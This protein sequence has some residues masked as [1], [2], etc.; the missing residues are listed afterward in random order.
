[1]NDNL[2]RPEQRNE[3]GTRTDK[4]NVRASE[5]LVLFD[6]TTDIEDTNIRKSRAITIIT[7]HELRTSNTNLKKT[8]RRKQAKQTLIKSSKDK[9]IKENKVNFKT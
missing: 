9:E 2:F 7:V 5:M 3:E 1:M 6:I 8:N 4:K